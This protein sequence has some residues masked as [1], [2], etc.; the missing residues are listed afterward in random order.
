MTAAEFS[1]ALIA[2]NRLTTP[3]LICPRRED[4]VPVNYSDPL[5]DLVA[6]YDTSM[7]GT[8]GFDFYPNPRV[9]GRRTCV[10]TFWSDLVVIHEVGGTVLLEELGGGGHIMAPI[11]KN[12][13]AFLDALLIAC[14]YFVESEAHDP[15]NDHAI[16][17]ASRKADPFFAIG[18]MM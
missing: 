18:A 6:N 2:G 15:D 11:A 12:G 1:Q 3:S 13:S 7:L 9:H 14:R 5:L 16:S 4:R 17:R 10:G 8:G